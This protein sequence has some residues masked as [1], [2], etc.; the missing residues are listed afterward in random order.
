MISVISLNHKM[1]EDGIIRVM[2]KAAGLTEP[3]A[4]VLL[5]SLTG[6]QVVAV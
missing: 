4:D 3:D 6:D 5:E 1:D 2:E